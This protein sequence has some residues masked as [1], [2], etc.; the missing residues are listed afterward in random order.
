MTSEYELL[1]TIT[2]KEV[3]VSMC[4]QK[5]KNQMNSIEVFKLISVLSTAD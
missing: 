3:N 1:S 2:K 5:K 4:F